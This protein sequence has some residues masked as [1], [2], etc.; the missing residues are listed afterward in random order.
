M[1][2]G[3]LR[4]STVCSLQFAAVNRHNVLDEV[5]VQN[6]LWAVSD[7]ALYRCL[8]VINVNKFLSFLLF[9]YLAI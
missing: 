6:V 2:S 5:A 3:E 9:I 8:T 7:V 4:I 1:I